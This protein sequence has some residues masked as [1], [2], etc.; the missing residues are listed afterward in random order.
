VSARSM[1][2]GVLTVQKHQIAVK[3]Y[4]A[5]D[6]R[7]VHFHLLHKR[8]RIRLQQRMVDPETDKPVEPDEMPKAFKSAPGL[9]V[10]VTPEEIERSEPKPTREVRLNQFVPVPAIDPRLFDRPYYL[11]PGTDSTVDYFALAHALDRKKFAGIATWV[12]RQH[13]YVGALLT[14]NGHLMLITLRHADEVIPVKELDP[15]QGGAL[16]PKE[17]DLAGKLI[18]ALSGEFDPETYHDEYQRWVHELIEA[19]RAGKKA[20]PQRVRRPQPQGS[21]AESL[22]SSLKKVSARQRH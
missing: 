19:K 5:V 17:R 8:D 7:Q 6:D 14:H 13:S 1:W 2:Q 9:Y 16:E 11:G 18:E 4:A 3:L 12:M 22:R 20:K 15:P 10:V 21:L